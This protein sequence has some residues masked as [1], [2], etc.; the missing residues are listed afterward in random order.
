MTDQEHKNKLN[1][2]HLYFECDPF[3]EKPCWQVDIVQQ[4]GRL[5]NFGNGLRIFL[6]ETLD[7][8]K[9]SPD[10]ARSPLEAILGLFSFLEPSCIESD[11]FGKRDRFNLETFSG[12]YLLNCIGSPGQLKIEL[13]YRALPS[14]DARIMALKQ[15]VSESVAKTLGEYFVTTTPHPKLHE[16]V[17]MFAEQIVDAHRTDMWSNVRESIERQPVAGYFSQGVAQEGHIYGLSVDLELLSTERIPCHFKYDQDYKLE[18]TKTF[19][20]RCASILKE[21]TLKGNRSSGCYWE[22]YCSIGSGD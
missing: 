13:S 8:R 17:R 3:K 15:G 4:Q 2:A 11:D 9:P 12:T 18:D 7:F 1:K 22:S 19:L 16:A 14:I 6:N 21:G 5:P 20:E 10:K